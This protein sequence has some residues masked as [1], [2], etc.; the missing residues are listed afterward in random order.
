MMSWSH[1]YASHHDLHLSWLRGQRTKRISRGR[2]RTASILTY[3]CWGQGFLPQAKS[4]PMVARLRQ[5]YVCDLAASP[6]DHESLLI[7][8]AVPGKKNQVNGSPLKVTAVNDS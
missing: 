7:T 6:T 2:G 3:D 1:L 8:R 4:R 5:R